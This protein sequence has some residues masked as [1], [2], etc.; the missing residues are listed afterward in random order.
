M[1]K[2]SPKANQSKNRI[3][4]LACKIPT[5]KPYSTYT[6]DVNIRRNRIEHCCSHPQSPWPTCS[7]CHHPLRENS[8][9][10]KQVKRDHVENFLCLF[11]SLLK[12][13]H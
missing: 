5:V 1:S 12:N 3:K 6:N 10:L 11:L 2:K 13:K 7:V 8:I 4:N 9:I